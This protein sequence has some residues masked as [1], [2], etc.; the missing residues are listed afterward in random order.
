MAVAPLLGAANAGAAQVTVL[1]PHGTVTHRFDPGVAA[2]DHTV[3]PRVR[4]PRAAA[5]IAVRRTTMSELRRLHDAGSIDPAAFAAYRTEY[6]RDT[7]LVKTL[8]GRRRIEMAGV[9]RNLDQMAARGSLTPTRLVP[10][11]LQLQR[12]REWWSTGPLLAS[13]ARV[14][15]KGSELV[16]QYAPGEGLEIHPLANFGKLNALWRSKA[17]YDRMVD[18]LDELLPLGASRA[19]GL[20]WEYYYDFGGGAPP[21]VSSLSQGTGLQAMARAARKAGTG[22]L[23]YPVLE[24]GLAVFKTRTPSGVRVPVGAGNH[25]AQYSFAPGLRIL[26][27]FVQSLVGLYDFAEITGDTDAQALFASGEARA[28]QEVP[29]Y[30][31]GAWSLYDRG[32]DSHESNLNYHEVLTEFLSSLCSRTDEPVFCDTLDH[33]RAYLKQDPAV[34]VVTRSLRAGKPGALKFT[35]SK[36]S[37]VHVSLSRGGKV[38]YSTTSTLPYGTRSIPLTPPRKAKEYV[39]HIDATDLAGNATS[40]DD[41]VAVRK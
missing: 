35:L 38:V 2:R 11:F 6:R 5:T 22:D 24:Q 29:T 7:A 39:V 25:Y 36:I 8:T 30:D 1:G 12:N 27:G 20:A 17:D 40:I 15:F 23:V 37:A 32:T 16:F 34:A 28:L 4:V 41:T 33:F 13:G 10:L 19:G 18:L 26:N 31:T 14:S 9:L 21:W 3:A